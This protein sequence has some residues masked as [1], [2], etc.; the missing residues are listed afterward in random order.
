MA[1]LSYS[2]VVQMSSEEL[3]KEHENEREREKEL[4]SK[5]CVTQSI[6]FAVGEKNK[7]FTS[8]NVYEMFSCYL[9]TI[10]ARDKEVIAVWL[11]IL[12]GRC[13]IYLSKNSDWLDKDI[14]YVDNITKYLKNISKN[15]PVISEDNEKDFLM[16]VTLYCSTKLEFRLK[17]LKDDIILYGDN[18]HVKSFSKFLSARIA[19]VGNAENTNIIMISGICKEY[20]KKVKKANVESKIPSEFLRHIKKVVS[21][22][23]SAIGIVECARNIQYKSLFS[24]VRVFKKSPVIINNQPYIHGKILSKGLLMK[25]NINV[26]WMGVQKSLK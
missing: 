26:S 16:A 5:I 8:L 21:Y 17:K 9:A 10:L 14:E 3:L 23:A 1:T 25:I 11:R 22:M 15:A 6:H 7:E 12:Q 18:K 20:Y 2:Q 4:Y 13:K 19:M 24:N